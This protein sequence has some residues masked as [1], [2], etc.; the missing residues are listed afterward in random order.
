MPRF[1]TVVRNGMIIN[2]T[3]APCYRGDVG[4]KDGRIAEIGNLSR[5]CRWL[6]RIPFTT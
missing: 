4:I 6:A 2:G 3:R 5:N 1:D